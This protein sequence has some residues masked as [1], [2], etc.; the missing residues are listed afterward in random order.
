M[1]MVMAAGFRTVLGTEWDS[2]GAD[3]V[4]CVLGLILVAFREMFALVLVW[5]ESDGPAVL[6]MTVQ[7]ANGA[8]P[9]YSRPAPRSGQPGLPGVAAHHRVRAVAA[10]PGASPGLHG[11]GAEGGDPAGCEYPGDV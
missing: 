11:A 4:S 6:V 7:R 3:F 8:L 10:V 1:E 5:L 2:L 9:L